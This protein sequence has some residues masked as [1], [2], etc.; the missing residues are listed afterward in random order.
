MTTADYQA[1]TQKSNSG[2]CMSLIG[3]MHRTNW[4]LTFTIWVSLM[5]KRD[6]HR[7]PATKTGNPLEREFSA[8]KTNGTGMVRASFRS[9]PLATNP[10]SRGPRVWIP[11]TPGMQ[12]SSRDWD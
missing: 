5:S 9:E 6:T 11:V 2:G 10:S 12:S 8:Q 1:V 7:E 4:V 3:L